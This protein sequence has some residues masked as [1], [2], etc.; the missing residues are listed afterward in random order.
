[1]F[2]CP[3]HKKPNG[4]PTQSALCVVQAVPG[5]SRQQ[6]RK[7]MIRLIAVAGF[8][9]AVATSAQAMTTAPISQPDGMITHVAYACG[10]GRTRVGSV[11]VARTTV[12]HARWEVRRCAL[13]RV[14][15]RQLLALSNRT[16]VLRAG[17]STYVSCPRS[18]PFGVEILKV[19]KLH[20]F[21]D[22]RQCPS[23]LRATVA[24]MPHNQKFRFLPNICHQQEIYIR[25]AKCDEPES[26]R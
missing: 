17:Q 19:A 2:K 4:G 23:G 12:R 1:L 25:G 7:R 16:G 10:P 14:E 3:K 9:I 20:E 13:W 8:A 15:R 18:A 22:V 6:G 11:C 5:A 24:K 26:S 21:S